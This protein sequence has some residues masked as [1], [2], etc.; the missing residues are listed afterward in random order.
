MNSGIAQRDL[1]LLASQLIT[2]ELLFAVRAR[3]QSKQA[4]E[5]SHGGTSFSRLVEMKVR[6]RYAETNTM[7]DGITG[8]CERYYI[9]FI[10]MVSCNCN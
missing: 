9:I 4:L 3:N 5:F 8:L 1:V 10:Q 6:A 2:L 7:Y